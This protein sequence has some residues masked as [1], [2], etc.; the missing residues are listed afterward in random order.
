VNGQQG[1]SCGEAKTIRYK[2]K[3]NQTST[4]C[5]LPSLGECSGSG[6]AGVLHRK[7]SMDDRVA[8]KFAGGVLNGLRG[9]SQFEDESTLS[10]RT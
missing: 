4:R 7:G 6:G 2:G 5:F 10:A 9:H 8:V 3:R 1:F